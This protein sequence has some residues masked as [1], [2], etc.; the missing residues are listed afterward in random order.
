MGIAS[1]WQLTAWLAVVEHTTGADAAIF[2]SG[3]LYFGDRC[4]CDHGMGRVKNIVLVGLM[5][6][7]IGVVAAGCGETTEPI[8]RTPQD[9]CLVQACSVYF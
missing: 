9:K 6:A 2:R 1:A 3:A 8:T 7:A 5:L 4:C